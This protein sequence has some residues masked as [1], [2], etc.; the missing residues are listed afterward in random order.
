MNKPYLIGETI[1]LRTI[2]AGDLTESYRQWFN[3]GEVCQFNSH[4]R[5]PSYQENLT[6]YFRDVIKSKNNLVLAI[7]DK[8]N[9]AH[10]GNI[11]LQNL[12][13]IDRS[14]ELA[15]IIGNKDY[16][17]KGVGEE[18]CNLIVSHGFNAL[19]LHRIYCGTSE[20]NA[21]MQKLAEKL[22]FKKEGIARDAIFKEGSY[23]NVFNYGL[24]G[25]DYGK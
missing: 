22:G 12:N 6:D 23:H 3:D 5:F 11:A 20:K 16:W 21:G 7:V 15:I 4:H 10:V 14:A 1:Y 24:L 9:D 17:R 19:N 8:K 25:S 18:A 13:Y 2:E